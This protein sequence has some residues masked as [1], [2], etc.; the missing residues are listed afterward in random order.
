VPL[1][2]AL[3]GHQFL[4]FVALRRQQSKKYLFDD[5]PSGKDSDWSH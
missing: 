2:S 1:H 4:D 5:K 3:T